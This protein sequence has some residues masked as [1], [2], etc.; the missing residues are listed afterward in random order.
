[1]NCE[2]SLSKTLTFLI[3]VGR[4]PQGPV[5]RR[6]SFRPRIWP[7]IQ[8]CRQATQNYVQASIAKRIK[9]CIAE[10][11]NCS[12]GLSLSSRFRLCF[13]MVLCAN[14]LQCHDLILEIICWV[15]TGCFIFAISVQVVDHYKQYQRFKQVRDWTMR[16]ILSMSSNLYKLDELNDLWDPISSLF[17]FLNHSMSPQKIFWGIHA[18]EGAERHC[19]S[20]VTR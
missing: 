13:K 19:D 6:L 9:G 15:A 17:W 5:L 14:R 16:S 3:C 4:W 12:R 20:G 8:L 7:T 2:I 18:D 11:I 10:E 1:M